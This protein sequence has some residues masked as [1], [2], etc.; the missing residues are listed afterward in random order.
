M[1]VG[2]EAN[3]TVMTIAG[4][5]LLYSVLYRYCLVRKEGESFKKGTGREFK[6]AIMFPLHVM[7]KFPIIPAILCLAISIIMTKEFVDG[8]WGNPLLYMMLAEHLSMFF[9]FWIITAYLIFAW[10]KPQVLPDGEYIVMLTT[11]TINLVLTA[12]HNPHGTALDL[13][14]HQFIKLDWV[15]LFAVTAVE[16]KYRNNVTLAIVRPFIFILQGAWLD[17]LGFMLYNPNYKWVVT[18]NAVMF[19]NV[20]FCIELITVIIL[21]CVTYA[22]AHTQV[23]RMNYHEVSAKLDLEYNDPYTKGRSYH[24]RVPEECFT[25]TGHYYGVEKGEGE[26]LVYDDMA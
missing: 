24:E 8:F 3:G 6:T 9:S 11:F 7:P 18:E 19:S 14:V 13:H 1:F 21:F 23:S 20:F 15:I 22:I 2:H 17:T 25:K 5:Y 4:I 16:C 10:F 12:N 26:P